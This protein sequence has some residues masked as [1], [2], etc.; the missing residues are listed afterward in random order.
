M[1]M[2]GLPQGR[3][4]GTLMKE[5][6]RVSKDCEIEP[7]RQAAIDFLLDLGTRMGLHGYPSLLPD[8]AT[9]PKKKTSN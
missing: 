1:A 9:K 5:L 8:P 6:T 7:T 4:V 3:E 2:F